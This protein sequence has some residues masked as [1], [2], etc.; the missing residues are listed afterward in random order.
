M[1]I[2]ELEEQQ[3]MSLKQLMI[4]RQAQE[5]AQ[6][7]A[8]ELQKELDRINQN[9]QSRNMKM[10]HCHKPAELLKVKKEGPRQGRKFW[11]CMQRECQFFEWLPRTPSPQPS[12]DRGIPSHTEYHRQSKEEQESEDGAKRVRCRGPVP[13]MIDSD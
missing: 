4:S 12:T 10:C 11:K 13:Q 7:Q 5:T 9:A 1:R 6:I 3:Q 2:L 8:A